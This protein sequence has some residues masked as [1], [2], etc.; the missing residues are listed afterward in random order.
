M[1]DPILATL[2]K[3]RPHYSQ[4]NREKKGL[5]LGLGQSSPAMLLSPNLFHTQE[6]VPEAKDSVFTLEAIRSY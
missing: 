1:C 6:P 4:T 2:L 5:S 3:M